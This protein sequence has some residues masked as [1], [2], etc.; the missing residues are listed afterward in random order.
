MAFLHLLLELAFF[1]AGRWAIAVER[2]KDAGL[3]DPSNLFPRLPSSKARG[4]CFPG[5]EGNMSTR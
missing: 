5:W 4:T 3:Q 1:I 2:K